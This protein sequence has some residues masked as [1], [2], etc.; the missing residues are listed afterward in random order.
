LDRIIADKAGTAA[1]A[2]S[3]AR[4]LTPEKEEFN[5]MGRFL[6]DTG[7]CKKKSKRA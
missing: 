3:R 2:V 7:F 5:G 4:R 1:S 6:L